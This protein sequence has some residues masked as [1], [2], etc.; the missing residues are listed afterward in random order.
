MHKLPL[1]SLGGAESDTAD[2]LWNIWHMCMCEPT[3]PRESSDAVDI[4]ATGRFGCAAAIQ[5]HR[6]DE[7]TSVREVFTHGIDDTR[8]FKLLQTYEERWHT[9]E[10]TGW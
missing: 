4:R 7:S 6:A 10:Y 9:I 5:L 3:C 8:L 1:S 2:A